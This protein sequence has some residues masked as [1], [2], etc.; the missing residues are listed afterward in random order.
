M[1][2]SEILKS[3]A[4]HTKALLLKELEIQLAELQEKWQW[5]SLERIFIENEIYEDIKKC[6]T[7][8]AINTTIDEGLKP[9]VK[10]LLRPVTIDDILKL[11]EGEG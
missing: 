7:D 3:S 5:V 8:E 11:I 4:E 9:F 6:T 10:N 1:S 2:V